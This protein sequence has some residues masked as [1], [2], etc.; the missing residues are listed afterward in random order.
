MPLMGY[1][2]LKEKA[3]LGQKITDLGL[4]LENVLLSDCC[5]G[6]KVAANDESASGYLYIT[7]DPIGLLAGTNTYS[8]ANQNP[9]IFYDFYGL[10]ST[11]SDFLNRAGRGL[12]AATGNPGTSMF[13]DIFQDRMINCI[14]Q[15]LDPLCSM[16]E[17]IPPPPEPPSNCPLPEDNVSPPNFSPAD[18]IDSPINLPSFPDIRPFPNL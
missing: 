15:G 5:V 1:A 4:R 18:P 17:E 7:S 2:L 11:F 6:K 14:S 12:G 10:E 8:Y 13:V 16:E 9:L 3:P